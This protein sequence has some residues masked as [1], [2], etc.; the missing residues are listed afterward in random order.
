M[1][2]GLGFEFSRPCVTIPPPVGPTVRRVAYI[3]RIGL[4][5][6][7]VQGTRLVSCGLVVTGR[8]LI[9]YVLCCVSCVVSRRCLHTTES[10]SVCS[11]GLYLYVLSRLVI[12]RVG[13]RFHDT[14]YLMTDCVLYLNN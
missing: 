10:D 9:S 3:I 6:R 14:S 7:V 1:A 5:P 13:V 11:M 4:C 8:V 2:C 12:M